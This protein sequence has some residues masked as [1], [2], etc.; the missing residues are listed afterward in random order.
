MPTLG[1]AMIV[2][3]AAKTLG[4]CLGSVRGIFDETVVVDTGSIDLTKKIASESGARIHDFPWI[5]DFAAARNFSF[6]K[7]TSDYVMWLDSV[8][9]ETPVLVRRSGSNFI[10]YVEI[11]DLVSPSRRETM[12]VAYVNSDYEV[13]THLG[14]MPI[15]AIKQHHVWKPVFRVVDEGDVR[16]TCDHSLMSGGTEVRGADVRPGMLLDHYDGTAIGPEVETVTLDLAEAWG[17]FAAEGWASD[18]LKTGRGLWTV[19]NTD[20]EKLRKVQHQFEAAHTRPFRIV[21]SQKAKRNKATCFRLEPQDPKTLAAVYRALFY[22]SGGRKKIPRE[23]LNGTQAIKEAFIRGYE[24]GDGH[25]RRIALDGRALQSWSTNS[26]VLAAGLFHLYRSV[27]R[28]LYCNRPRP[29]KPNIVGCV[30]SSVGPTRRS[31]WTRAEIE[32][33]RKSREEGVPLRE[34]A[35]H[36]GT[37][38]SHVSNIVHYGIKTAADE[39]A[40]SKPLDHSVRAVVETPHFEGWVYDLN[41]EAGTFVGGVGDFILH[42]SDDLVLPEER[43]KI[44]TLKPKLGESDCW[45]MIYDYHQDEFG[46]SVMKFPLYRIVKNRLGIVWK[47][48][49]HEGMIFPKSTRMRDTDIVIT[50]RRPLGAIAGHSARNLRILECAVREDPE[51]MRMRFYYAKELKDAGRLNE[52]EA[53]FETFIAGGGDFH[54]NLVHAHLMLA[55]VHRDLNDG[56]RAVE[57]CARGIAVDPRWAE[58][59]FAAGEI[60]YMKGEWRKA[61]WWFERA[62]ACPV[63]ESLGFTRLD[64][65]TWLPA[66]R[67]C[68]CHAELGDLRRAHKENEKALAYRPDEPRFIG[69]KRWLEDQLFGRLKDRPFRLNLGAGPK[70]V[71]SYRKCDLYPGPDIDFVFDQCRLPYHTATVHAVYSEHALEHAPG[72]DQARAALGEWARALRHGGHLVLKVPDMDRCCIGF[73]NSQDRPRAA[74]ERY[75]EKEWYRYTIHG[76]QKSQGNEPDEGQYH[77]T[78]FTKAELRRLL[79]A[80]GFEIRKLEEYDGWGTPSI[81]VDAVQTRQPVRVSWLVRGGSEDEPSTRIRR[82][83][84]CVWLARHGL[85]SRI[86]KAY[87]EGSV[88]VGAIV[89]EVR[90]SDVAVFTQFSDQDVE[91]MERLNRCGVATV[92]DLN[93]DLEDQRPAL[94]KALDT[95]RYSVFC[96]TELAAKWGRDLRHSVIKDAY[97]V[98]GKPVEHA[99]LPHGKDGSVRVLW[100]GMGGNAANADFLRPICAELGMEFLVMSEWPGH[101]IRWNRETWLE[102][103]ASADIVVSPQRVN[104]QNCKSNTK[105]TQAMAL[106]IPVCVSPLPAYR[107]CITDG[108]NGFICGTPEEWKKALLALR[109]DAALREGIGKAARS[110]VGPYSPDAVGAQWSGLLGTLSRENCDPPKVDIIV[111]TFNNL[112]YLKECV[113]SVRKNTDWPHNLIVVNSGTDGTAEWL[114]EQPDIIHHNSAGRLHF[115]EA[116][117]VGLGIAKERYVCLLNDDTIVSQGWLDALMHEAMKPGVGAVGPFSNCDRGWLHDGEIRAGGLDLVPGMDLETV[118]PVIPEIYGWKRRKEIHR[119]DWVAFYCTV[120]PRKAVDTVGPLDVGFKSGDEDLDYCRRLNDAGFRCRQTYDSFVFHFGGRTR[121]FAEGLDP[122]LHQAEDRGNHEHYIR[123]WGSFGIPKVTEPEEQAA[124]PPAPVPAGPVARDGR[125]LFVLYTGAAWERWSPKSVDEGGIGGSE[126]CAVY[127]AKEFA[128][129]GWKSVVF[130]DCA[131]REGDYDG[132]EY[133]DHTRFPAFASANGM[134]LFVSSRRTDVFALKIR[135]E[136]KAVWV[137]DIFLDA[138]PRADLRLGAYDRILL[139]S[140]WHK[141]FFMNHHKGVPEDKIRITRDGI[142]LSRFG[143]KLRKI[144]GR[145]VYSSSPDRGLEALIDMLPVIQKEVPEAEVHVFYGFE[146][147]EKSA[148][149]RNDAGQIALIERLKKK[150]GTPGVV[151]RGRVG[152]KI[153]AQEFMKAELWAFCTWFTETFCITACEAMASGT[154]IVTAD[155]AALQTTVG[156]AGVLVP[157]AKNPY[158]CGL[159]DDPAFRGRFVAECIRMLTDRERW[160]EYSRRGLEKA[161]LYSWEGIVDEWLKLL[162]MTVKA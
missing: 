146:N 112:A 3:D 26:P 160:E 97:E 36:Y 4:A 105:A 156:D 46:N 93:E 47:W 154:P 68:K 96:S 132:V 147:W 45:L 95:A 6:S 82:L 35:Q 111:P 41:T 25:K 148:R 66:D 115:A 10:D 33:L 1:L 94:R 14:W 101:D 18:V 38:E 23:I 59:Y 27:G 116:N 71:P 107:E 22:S 40:L 102:T 13:M 155:V 81:A 39:R 15:R 89:N 77:R 106:G 51:D 60:H 30:E 79:E 78:G 144:P 53:N 140:P 54:E 28:R 159:T 86:N 9:G 7:V 135:A 98:P 87:M 152:Q 42:N 90:L 142:D 136:R 67:L 70:P 44:L 108:K 24:A 64:Q 74:G 123:K 56:K 124:A 113:K 119:R 83:N 12:N 153:L 99:Y 29:D 133:L 85:D 118:R 92:F 114:K 84:V 138:D 69:N 62:A 75:T 11:R 103:L 149:Q 139:L 76:I 80:N 5:D 58:F 65:Y 109:D 55:E 8:T 72:H 20:Q 129:R 48:P 73:I 61:A 32:Q 117:N 137:H 63:P 126:T 21:V 37:S 19:Y 43:K 91:I 151:Y 134:E 100:S 150:L 141:K 16:V 143:R 110:S 50:H 120:L 127:V 2:R 52:A 57:A 130:G 121:K 145:M 158:D 161:K 125:P 122:A 49:V 31:R 17:F 88:D 128:K 104:I 157:V 34:L 131:D 162:D